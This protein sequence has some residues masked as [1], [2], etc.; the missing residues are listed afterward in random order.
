[1]A[2]L[3]GI[4]KEGFEETC[5]VKPWGRWKLGT[6]DTIEA[7]MFETN[8]YYI[9][10]NN[11]VVYDRI[12]TFIISMKDDVIP[13]ES[14]INA[15]RSC[16]RSSRLSRYERDTAED[17]IVEDRFKDGT[18]ILTWTDLTHNPEWCFFEFFRKELVNTM[19]SLAVSYYK[20]DK[21]DDEEDD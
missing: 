1:M 8:P 2:W 21:I 20:I 13:E 10:G 19:N 3:T 14:F 12:S 15:F 11:N 16:V 7:E 9:S 5:K 18:V 6:I 17:R 4:K